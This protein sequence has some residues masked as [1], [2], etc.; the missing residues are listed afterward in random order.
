MS[1]V[2]E[3][4]RVSFVSLSVVAPSSQLATARSCQLDVPVKFNFGLKYFHQQIHHAA[5][6]KAMSKM[7]PSLGLGGRAVGGLVHCLR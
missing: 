1:K 5:R 7:I 3:L 6:R 2:S 4:D